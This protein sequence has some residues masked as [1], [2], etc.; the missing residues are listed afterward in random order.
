MLDAFPGVATNN[1]ST[2]SDNF[3]CMDNIS[4]VRRRHAPLQV[5]N[6]VIIIT[7]AW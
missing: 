6:I 4:V 7:D 1:R 5:L 2:T 3:D